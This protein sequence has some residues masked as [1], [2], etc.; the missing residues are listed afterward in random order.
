MIASSNRLIYHTCSSTPREAE[1]RSTHRAHADNRTRHFRVHP[2]E[3]DLRHRPAL[4][5]RDP[6]DAA[7]DLLGALRRVLVAVTLPAACVARA[8][9]RKRA[10]EAA[11]E[12]RRPWDDPDASELAVLEHLALLL[13]V[14][15]CLRTWRAS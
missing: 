6:L 8:G 2:R 5:A 3:C 4:V 14:N 13:S 9:L 7:D 11:G 15:E 1:E 12:E 10:R